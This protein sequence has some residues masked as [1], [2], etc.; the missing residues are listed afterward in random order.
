MASQV[1]IF[2]QALT[3]LGA[4]RVIDANDNTRN[5]RTLKAIYEAKRDA[6]LAAQPWTFA[7][8]RAQ[9]PA[10]GTAPA[11]GWSRA[12][13]LPSDYLAMV[14]VGENYTLY[15]SDC[16]PLFQIESHLAGLA[17]MTNQVAPLRVRYI[18]RVTNPGLFPPLFVEALAC[19]L[20]AEAC[21]EIT[22]SLSKR[23][24]AWNE[25]QQALREAR[26]VNAIEQPPRKLPDG[27]WARTMIEG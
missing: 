25:R 6:E 18:S 22:Q 11:F 8:K 14:E 5:A 13:P 19:R 24:A 21:E 26:R 7:I 27:T 20:A 9:L 3:K 1:E 2:N 10:S 17:I 23:E 12:F 4:Q 16:G 15:L